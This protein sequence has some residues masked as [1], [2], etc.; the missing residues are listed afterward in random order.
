MCLTDLCHEHQTLNI[1]LWSELISFI[2]CVLAVYAFRGEGLHEWQMFR[3][4]CVRVW[5]S[6]I[7]MI[8]F[9]VKS[10]RAAESD[11]ALAAGTGYVSPWKCMYVN[12]RMWAFLQIDFRAHV[13]AWTPPRH[14]YCIWWW[15]DEYVTQ[16]SSALFQ[17]WPPFFLQWPKTSQLQ[18]N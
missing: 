15:D 13:S 11:I 14:R 6:C 17:V 1:S 4:V 12:A 3:T 5:K 7:C 8:Q 10:L 2:K 16:H 9:D 18:E